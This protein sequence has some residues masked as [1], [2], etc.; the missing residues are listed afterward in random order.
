MATP[1][2]RVYDGD[3]ARLV[4]EN[5]AFHQALADIETEITES[6]KNAPARDHEG[7]EQLWQLLKLAGK[8]R[9]NLQSRMETGKL[10]RLEL[11]HQRKSMLQKAKELTGLA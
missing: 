4:L 5:E 11:D 3:Q 9:T 2:Q 6:W 8:L 7:R 10:A 1:D